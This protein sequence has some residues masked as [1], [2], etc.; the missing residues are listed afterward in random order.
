MFKAIT[1]KEIYDNSQLAFVFEF[2]T[3]MN[4]RELAA[5]LSRALG[6]GV[7]WSTDI[8]YQFEPTHESFKLAPVYSNSYKESSL[9]TGFMP[10]QEAV[11]M[12]LKMMNLIESIGYTTSRCAV[13]TKIRLNTDGVG[14][15]TKV[16]SLNKFKYL[17][18]LNEKQLFEWWPASSNESGHVYTNQ[19]SYIQPKNLFSTVVTERLVERMSPIEFSFPTSDFFAN[20]FSEIDRDTMI[21]KYIAGKDYQAKKQEAVDSINL[22]IE[23]LCATLS[24]NYEYSIEE[25]RQIY[26]L[27]ENFKNAI[28]AT[29][30]YLNFRSK[31]PNLEIYVDLRNDSRI[32]EANYDLLREKLFK[33]VLGG[34]VTEGVINYDGRRKALQVKDAQV[35]RGMLI[36][37]V[38]F[39]QCTVSADA[40]LCLFEGCTVKNSKLSE[41]TIFSNNFIK[42]S[43][44]LDCNYLGDLNEISS[45][46]LDNPAEKKINAELRECLVNRGQ[47]TLASRVDSSTK[48]ISKQ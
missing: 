24:N 29:K 21:I 30:S 10:Y 35:S 47:F 17:L 37:G 41:C 32:I 1:S 14:L 36:E 40:K 11:H 15:P 19:I 31:Y 5:K 45:S 6:K 39:Y 28:D 13:T 12:L 18:G 33:L 20:D 9:S 3:P 8:N 7:K 22:V 48:V 27:T 34:G 43:K 26:T 4:K 46:Y 42:S 25:R 44:L 23:H 38:E 2:F 16:H